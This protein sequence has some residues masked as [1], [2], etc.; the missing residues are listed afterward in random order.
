MATVAIMAVMATVVMS[1]L[2]DSMR[3]VSSGGEGHRR[4]RQRCHTQHS[5]DRR[6]N[7]AHRSLVEHPSPLDPSI[8]PRQRS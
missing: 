4:A 3:V 1:V 8:R 2:E 5:K 6:A 7:A